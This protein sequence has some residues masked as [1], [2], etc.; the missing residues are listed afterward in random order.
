MNYNNKVDLKTKLYSLPNP[1]QEADTSNWLRENTTSLFLKTS[2][3][4]TI[5]T[6]N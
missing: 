2:N 1:L 3:S 4:L 6:R 5:S